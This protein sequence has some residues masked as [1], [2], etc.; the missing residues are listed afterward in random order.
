MAKGGETG[1]DAREALVAGS[2]PWLGGTPRFGADGVKT[3]RV[4]SVWWIRFASGLAMAIRG[5]K[6]GTEAVQLV[7]AQ[8]MAHPSLRLSKLVPRCMAL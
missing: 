2:G 6:A 4:A 8:H 1:D 3:E 5:T 7:G